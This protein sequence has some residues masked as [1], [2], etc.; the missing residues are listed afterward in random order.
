MKYFVIFF[1]IVLLFAVFA[2]PIFAYTQPKEPNPSPVPNPEKFNPIL[3]QSKSGIPNQDLVCHNNLFLVIKRT[4]NRPACVKIDSI[5][6]L[7]KRNWVSQEK[8]ET[9]SPAF[10]AAQ[11]FVEKSPTFSFDGI[12]GVMGMGNLSDETVLDTFPPTY[13]LSAEFATRHQG[14]GDRSGQNLDEKSAWHKA[15]IKVKG[16]TIISAIYDDAWDELNQRQI[17]PQKQES[18]KS[19]KDWSLIQ[20]DPKYGDCPVSFMSVGQNS[21][22]SRHPP[23]MEVSIFGKKVDSF[24]DAKKTTGMDGL[25]LPKYIP[26]CLSLKAVYANNQPDQ[27]KQIVAVY[28]LNDV[29]ISDVTYISDLQEKGLVLNYWEDKDAPSSE[30]WINYVDSLKAEAPQIRSSM[31]ID[32][33]TVLLLE[34]NH[35]RMD[36]AQAQMILGDKRI[37]IISGIMETDE[38]KKITSSMFEEK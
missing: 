32:N 21:E 38:I 14:Y 7:V 31:K 26:E 6:H 11:R 19:I 9:S 37:H 20:H 35:L 4:D 33:A 29:D 1:S 34:R 22:P 8:L 30:W 13:T 18:P 2:M 28:L 27:L 23:P 15:I 17:H 5:Y 36:P 12:L 3:K 25:Q 24:E 10:A 16:I